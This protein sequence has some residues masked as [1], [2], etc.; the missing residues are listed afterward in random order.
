[1]IRVN[2]IL[3]ELNFGGSRDYVGRPIR[4]YKIQKASILE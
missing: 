2:I 3:K 4:R 1:M